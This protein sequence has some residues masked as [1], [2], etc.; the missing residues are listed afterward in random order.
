M[1]KLS[2]GNQSVKLRG[3]SVV[4]KDDFNTKEFFKHFFDFLGVVF[5]VVL[6]L[7]YCM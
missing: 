4:L 6:N 2:M 3:L 1:V 5:V 7:K